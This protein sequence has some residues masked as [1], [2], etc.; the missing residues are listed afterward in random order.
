MNILVPSLRFSSSK[1]LIIFLEE[2]RWENR[3]YDAKNKNV[4]KPKYFWNLYMQYSSS[5]LSLNPFFNLPTR[6]P[7]FFQPGTLY[8]SNQ[9]P[10]TL[11]I[12]YPFFYKSGTFYSSM[13]SGSLYFSNQGSF[14]LSIRAIYSSNQELFTLSAGDPLLFQLETL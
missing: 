11:P 13:Q 10:F 6:D 4:N 1:Y 2:C 8:S 3:Q 5:Y 9:G 12:T 7:L 14:S